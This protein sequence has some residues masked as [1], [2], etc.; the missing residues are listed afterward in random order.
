MSVRLF[1]FTQNLNFTSGKVSISPLNKK[2]NYFSHASM[3]SC[4]SWLRKYS[5]FPFQLFTKLVKTQRQ[6]THHEREMMIQAAVIAFFKKRSVYPCNYN[7]FF[8][9]GKATIAAIWRLIYPDISGKLCIKHLLWALTILKQYSCEQVLSQ[10][11]DCTPKTFCKRVL[12][13]LT[14]LNKRYNDVVSTIFTI[15]NHLFWRIKSNFFK[16]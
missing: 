1:N 3:M 5:F 13:V 16:F 11:A 12:E 15:F 8:G 9:A 6:F 7:S 4:N 10:V 14:A 2:L